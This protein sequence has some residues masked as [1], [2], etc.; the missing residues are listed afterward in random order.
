MVSKDWVYFSKQTCG[1]DYM[2]NILVETAD[3]TCIPLEV[4]AYDPDLHP[5]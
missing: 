4:R 5:H 1:T 2:N 3:K